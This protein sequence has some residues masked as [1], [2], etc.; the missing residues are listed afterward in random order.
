VSA[1]APD[2]GGKADTL[3]HSRELRSWHLFLSQEHGIF[4]AGLSNLFEGFLIDLHA[5]VG[6][7]NAATF[8]R[9]LCSKSC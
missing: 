6:E 9:T 7:N 8:A 2:F 3:P 4:G 5:N 1:S